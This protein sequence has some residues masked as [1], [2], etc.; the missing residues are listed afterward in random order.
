MTPKEREAHLN[1]ILRNAAQEFAVLNRQAAEHAAKAV[2]ETRQQLTDMLA[3][4]AGESGEI[5]RTRIQSLMR[6]L[7]TVEKQIRDNLMD[8]TM[9]A[10]E[11]GAKRSTGAA[12]KAIGAA[13]GAKA[14]QEVAFNRVSSNVIR[15]VANRFAQDGLVLS[16]RIWKVSGEI[17]DQ[18]GAAIRKGV[19]QGK[20]VNTMIKDIRQIYSTET[21]K[22]RRL[23]VTEGN[24]AYRVATAYTAQQSKVVHLL[25][26]HRGKADR[27]THMCTIL[28]EQDPIGK[29]VG[30]YLPTDGR[31]YNPHPNCTSWLEYVL[32]EQ[33]LR[34]R[35]SQPQRAA[36]PAPEQPSDPTINL[37]NLKTQRE[38]ED[39]A[40]KHLGVRH[41]D[42]SDWEVAAARQMNLMMHRMKA[43]YPEAFSWGMQRIDS[44]Q[45]YYKLSYEAQIENMIDHNIKKSSFWKKYA[46]SDEADARKKLREMILEQKAITRE[47]AEAS[48]N[49]MASASGSGHF[50]DLR[51]IYI[52][53]NN[54]SDYKA[55]AAK[56]KAAAEA[57]W[58]AVG[59]TRGTMVHEYGH[60]LDFWMEEVGI[61]DFA[62]TL[63]ATASKQEA[64]WWKQNISQYGSTNKREMFAELFS[65]YKL[66]KEP[67]PIAQHFGQQLEEALRKHRKGQ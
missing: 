19:L 58:S 15:Y 14:A 33:M 38:H 3:A 10:V 49:A 13:V 22:I 48:T 59:T 63:W 11:D 9:A 28:S 53:R 44:L 26:I 45:S 16:D 7:D 56:K 43:E 32:D 54:T 61:R 25:R 17:R 51:G 37:V 65:E 64:D 29:G 55:F 62:D 40:K 1:S 52:N 2:Q 41:V 30:V 12:E 60:V 24:M 6:D 5:R 31:I 42:Y 66:A 8:A 46:E 27:P 20:S 35:Y 39:W 47:Y 36:E 4:A 67:R 50:Y 21:W 18:L 34:E 57:K 23:V